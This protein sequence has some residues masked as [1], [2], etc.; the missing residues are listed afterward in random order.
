MTGWLL[1]ALLL[2]AQPAAAAEAVP[3]DLGQYREI[4]T[5]SWWTS[6]CAPFRGGMPGDIERRI[7]RVEGA[8]ERRYGRAATAAVAAAAR[9]DFDEQFGLYDPVGRR[10]TPA[11]QQQERRN[12]RRWYDLRLDGLEA[13]LGLASR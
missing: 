1:L 10:L 7:E 3:A 6:C 11:Q 2:A 4:L 8:L 13:R 9:T 5:A 12:A